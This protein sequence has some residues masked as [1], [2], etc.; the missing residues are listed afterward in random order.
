MLA[1]V[2][3]PGRVLDPADLFSFCVRTMPRFTV[4]RYLR[5]VEDLPKTPSQRVQKF[6]L[7]AEGLTADTVDREALG[8]EVPR[9]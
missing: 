9:D 7:R 1:V 4:P 2:P 6:R 5:L 8:I 3:Q